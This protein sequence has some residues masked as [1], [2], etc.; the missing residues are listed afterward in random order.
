MRSPSHGGNQRI[1]MPK[2]IWH[3]LSDD[4]KVAWDTLSE[5][6][7]MLIF[8]KSQSPKNPWMTQLHKHSQSEDVEEEFLDA[9]DDSPVETERLNDKPQAHN[10]QHSHLPSSHL[11]TF[12]QYYHPKARKSVLLKPICLSHQTY[13]FIRVLPLP[14]N[15]S[16]PLLTEEPIDIL[17]VKTAK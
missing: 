12:R 6:D 3:S 13:L 10:T 1:L 2:E 5:E 14:C 11:A 15:P 9:F 4:G 8:G 16:S 17:R 7:K